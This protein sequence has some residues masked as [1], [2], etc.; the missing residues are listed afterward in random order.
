MDFSG[1]HLRVIY[2]TMHWFMFKPEKFKKINKY[3]TFFLKSVK[4]PNCPA[5]NNTK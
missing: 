1:N 5:I 3:I 2:R 4:L